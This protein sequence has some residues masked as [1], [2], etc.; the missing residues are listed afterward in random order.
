M[1]E[2]AG[3][4]IDAARIAAANAHAPYSRFGVGAAVLLDDGSVVTGTNFENASYG[5]SL[6]AE[7]V[8]LAKANSEGRLRQVVEIGVIGGMLGV[9]GA[10]TG[11]DPV[12]PCGRCR[13]ILNEAAQLA[14]RD[15][16]VHCAS[17]DG[18]TIETHR[19]SEL[20]PH[21]FG[22]ADLGIG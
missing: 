7:T 3:R 2:T 13:Q 19:L 15:I 1:N 12:R 18:A 14:G 16:L 5:L 10:I 9:D 17:A 4:L 6:C 22:P 8:A 20:L 21:A 11:A